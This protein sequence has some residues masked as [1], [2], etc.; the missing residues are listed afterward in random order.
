[1]K[2][3][4]VR[5]SRWGIGG[6]GIAM[7][8]LVPMSA[9]A[10]RQRSPN[11]PNQ[12]APSVQLARPV[13]PVQLLAAIA[14]SKR[15]LQLGDRGADVRVLQR[16]LSRNGLY[17]FAI[18][19]TYGQETAD[20]VAT[21]QR[22]RNLP[23][24]GVANEETLRDMDFDFLPEPVAPPQASSR[25]PN[26]SLRPGD[27]GADVSNLQNYLS[28]QGFYISTA[29]G[30]YGEE[31]AAAVTGYQRSRGLSISGVADEATLR[32]MGL[33]IAASSSASS[34]GTSRRNSLTS[35]GLV[36]GSQGSDVSTL[37]Q[38][39]NGFGISVAVD[40]DYGFAT[41]QAV[42]TYQ[43]VQ[44]LPVTGVAD[45][46]TLDSMGFS[47]P[48][49][50]Y[51]AAVI[52]DESELAAVRQYFEDAYVDRDRRGSFINIGSFGDRF[53]AEARVNAAK[54]RGFSTRVLY[55]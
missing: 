33:S 52:A 47:V 30:I 21:Y 4:A 11:P 28:R 6:L 49:Y 26:R 50:P 15:S 44:G 40:G 42:R 36:P 14:L 43:R 48:S 1:M 2:Q 19:D 51:V 16:Y 3:L 34:S 54:A 32:D 31:T 53:P 38:R 10:S 39:L 23:A 22:I 55:R 37:Q 17:P 45:Q 5:I 46:E 29:D 8:A 35:G 25:N 7:T 27:T 18:N 20:A 12:L 13:Q 24:T 41:E 9:L